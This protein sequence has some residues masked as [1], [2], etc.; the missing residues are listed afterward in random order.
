MF[1]KTIHFPPSYLGKKV[2][3]TLTC[4]KLCSLLEMGENEVGNYVEAGKQE[5]T[6]LQGTEKRTVYF[7]LCAV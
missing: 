5:N 6:D 2:I 7:S 4:D 3:S 1:V